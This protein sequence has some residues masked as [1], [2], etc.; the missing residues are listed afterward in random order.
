MQ[1]ATTANTIKE[2]GKEDLNIKET[3]DNHLK[4]TGEDSHKTL[5]K[6]KA[7][8]EAKERV[9]ANTEAKRAK[10]KAKAEAEDNPPMGIG[11]TLKKKHQ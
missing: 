4:T 6:A 9:K 8:E 1:E 7:K 11:K 10:A 2:K 5:H 3:G